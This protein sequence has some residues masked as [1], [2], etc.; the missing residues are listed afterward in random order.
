MKGNVMS[1]K[2]SSQMPVE[3]TELEQPTDAQLNARSTS[4]HTA[5]TARSTSGHT[6]RAPSTQKKLFWHGAIFSCGSVFRLFARPR[7]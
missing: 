4:E 7:L 5:H 1:R 6:T 2:P 3:P